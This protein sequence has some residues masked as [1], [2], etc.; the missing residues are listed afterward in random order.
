MV[1]SN[2]K[3]FNFIALIFLSNLYASGMK[4]EDAFFEFCAKFVA[5][6]KAEQ[7]RLAEQKILEEQDR[8][9]EEERSEALIKKT[10]GDYNLEGLD[11]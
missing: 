11:S 9:K 8:L 3:K 5:E 2:K 4:K 1:L 7:K 6:K 10:I